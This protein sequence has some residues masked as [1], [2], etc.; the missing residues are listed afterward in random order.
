MQNALNTQDY[1]L[2]PLILKINL[3]NRTSKYMILF[4]E[5]KN[6]YYSNSLLVEFSL[7]FF[8]WCCVVVVQCT[9]ALYKMTM[10]STSVAAAARRAVKFHLHVGI[11]AHVHI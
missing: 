9:V 6:Q 10:S 4:D 1:L 5:E 8:A 7:K 11:T 3:K 2:I